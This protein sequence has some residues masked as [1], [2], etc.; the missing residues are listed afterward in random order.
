MG[1]YAEEALLSATDDDQDDEWMEVELVPTA[2]EIAEYQLATLFYDF[3]L[4]EE[5]QDQ[6]LNIMKFYGDNVVKELL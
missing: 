4:S 3:N 6:I 2:W 5:V 1:E